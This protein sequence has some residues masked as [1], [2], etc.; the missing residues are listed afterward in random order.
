MK[1]TAI[2]TIASDLRESI[3]VQEQILRYGADSEVRG[4]T[5]YNICFAYWKAGQREKALAQALKLPNLY[6]SR[7][8]ALVHFLDG[9]EKAAVSRAALEPLA[10]AVQLHLNTLAEAEKNPVYREKAEIILANLNE[11]IGE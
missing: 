9:E 7:E 11:L 2:K 10:W 8:N 1:A 6:K 5:M 3:A 4:A